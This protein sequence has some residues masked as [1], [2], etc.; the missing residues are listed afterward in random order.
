M[1]KMNQAQLTPGGRDWLFTAI[2]NGLRDIRCP[3]IFE[4]SEEL[5]LAGFL[6]KYIASDFRK[7]FYPK[8]P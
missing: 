4:D 1:K 8:K 2:A 5:Q 3:H 6:T 7:K